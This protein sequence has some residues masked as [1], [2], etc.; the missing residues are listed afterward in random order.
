MKL[1]LGAALTLG[2][3]HLR[4]EIQVEVL[5]VRQLPEAFGQQVGEQLVRRKLFGIK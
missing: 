4:A 3:R 2:Q 5:E 1:G